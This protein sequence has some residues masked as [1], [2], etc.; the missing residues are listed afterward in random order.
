MN[1]YEQ[2]FELGW[3]NDLATAFTP[4][5]EAHRPARVCRVDRAGADLT[6]GSRVVRATYGGA[7]LR[8]SAHD[9][10]RLPAVGDWAA[11]RAWLDGRVTVEALLDRATGLMR[12]SADRTSQ[13]QVVA[14]NVDLVVIVEPLEPEPVIG[15]IERLLVLAWGS[16]GTPL[17]LLTKPD[18]VLDADLLREEVAAAAPGVDVVVANATT[19]AGAAAVRDR[20]AP[21][22]TMVMLGTSG[23]GKS[24]LVNALAQDDIMTT[25]AVREKDGRGRHTTKHRELIVLPGTGVVIDTPGLRSVGLVADDDALAS[26]FPEIEALAQQC[27]FR[28]C[29]HE[30][31]PGCAV[32]EALDNGTLSPIRMASWRKL[33]REAAL[34]ALRSDGRLRVTQLNEWRRHRR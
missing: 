19:Q 9:R 27:K 29:A 16:G 34:Q 2:L 1:G 30:T 11:V 32:Q 12:D 5:I 4:Y 28:D 7:L 20:I 14:A 3:T 6:D 22:Q 31:E 21:G 23:A 26:A 18:L 10:A 15:R 24:S 33:Q 25:A 13:A 17:V 8:E